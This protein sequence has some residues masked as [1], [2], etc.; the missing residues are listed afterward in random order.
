MLHLHPRCVA[1]HRYARAYE[2]MISLGVWEEAH[3]PKPLGRR[4]ANELPS[5]IGSACEPWIHRGIVFV[6]SKLLDEQSH[7]LEWS[8]GSSSMWYLMRVASLQ[9]IEHDRAWARRVSEFIKRNLSPQMVGRWQLDTITNSTPFGADAHQR[10]GVDDEPLSAFREYVTAPL[11]RASYSFVSV[12]GRARSEC[13]ARVLRE[14]LVEP[15]G[16][17]L[18]DNSLRRAYRAARAPLDASWSRVEFNATR[19]V[20]P[21][22]ATALWCKNS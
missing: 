19:T 15:G 3:C 14:G 11:R 17:L 12:D 21:D 8:T 9:S 16:L 6:L 5:E 20:H 10:P 13:L 4:R 22:A 1:L 2:E 7:A 18:L